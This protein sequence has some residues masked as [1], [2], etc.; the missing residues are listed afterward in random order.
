MVK[1]PTTPCMVQVPVVFCNSVVELIGVF[2]GSLTQVVPYKP[3]YGTQ[4]GFRPDPYSKTSVC[5]QCN[6]LPPPHSVARCFW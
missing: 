5:I 2:W 6:A 1:L 3:Y 4:Y